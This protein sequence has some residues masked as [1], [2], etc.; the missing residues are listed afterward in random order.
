LT[1]ELFNLLDNYYAPLSIG[2]PGIIRE[3]CDIKNIIKALEKC[4][5]DGLNG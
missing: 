2:L 1:E 5:K 4:Y 3:E